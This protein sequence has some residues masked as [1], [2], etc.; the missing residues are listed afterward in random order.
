MQSCILATD[1]G[2]HMSDIAD[3]KKFFEGLKEGQSI[4][5]NEKVDDESDE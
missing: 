3:L 1:M 2:R 5:D 4:I